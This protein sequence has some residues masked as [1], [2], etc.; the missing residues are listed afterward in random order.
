MQFAD[1][2]S[3]DQFYATAN[4]IS[5]SPGADLLRIWNEASA[6]GSLECPYYI[7]RK[8]RYGVVNL[9]VWQCQAAKRQTRENDRSEPRRHSP[10]PPYRTAIY[11]RQSAKI[12]SADG[13]NDAQ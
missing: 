5:V 1:L 3:S 12:I 11:P 13:K 2:A 4:R 7:G 6:G 8:V 10:N 9:K